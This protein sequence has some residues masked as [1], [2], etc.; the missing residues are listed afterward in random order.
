LWGWFTGPCR[1]F[2]RGQFP[3]RRAPW[4]YRL[5][6]KSTAD[7]RGV[8]TLERLLQA[9]VPAGTEHDLITSKIE[10]AVSR[11]E[12]RGATVIDRR[13][14]VRDLADALEALRPEIKESMLTA[15]EKAMFHLANGFS[16]RHHN[17]GQRGDY[18]KPVWLQWAFYVYLATIHAI[19][20][21][22]G[23]PES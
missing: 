11:F 19:L 21:V 1:Y 17:R 20:R 15:D 13:D 16:I 12:R 14:A 18:N 5:C 10:A 2:A 22:R 9:S 23:L 6:R 7:L 3:I 8:C 4:I